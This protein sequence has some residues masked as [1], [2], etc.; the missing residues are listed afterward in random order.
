MFQVSFFG[1]DKG[2][3][4]S[5]TYYF[6]FE[7]LFQVSIFGFDTGH[8]FTITT[9]QHSQ[10]YRKWTSEA[11]CRLMAREIRIIKQGQFIGLLYGRHWK[12]LCYFQNYNFWLKP[13]YKRKK[14]DCLTILPLCEVGDSSPLYC[15]Q[16]LSTKDTLK[17]VTLPPKFT[18][19]NMCIV[20]LK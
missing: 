6:R 11:T 20:I 9:L 4:F 10:G 3:F 13:V 18:S 5:V 7:F 19:C 15:F 2:H 8:F 17:R 1:F 14:V 12:I 16:L